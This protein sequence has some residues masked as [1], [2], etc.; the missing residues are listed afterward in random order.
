MRLPWIKNHEKPV[1]GICHGHQLFGVLYGSPLLRDE[2]GED[3]AYTVDIEKESA[4]FAGYKNKI[5][6]EQHHNYSIMLSEEFELL[7]S[8]PRCLVQAMKHK[9]KQIYGV[10][11]H[12]EKN[13]RLIRNFMGI[14]NTWINK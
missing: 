3:G 5:K 2:E 1:L 11:F 7:A 9:V 13:H 14:V 10:Q 12:A 6:V 8:S 4:L